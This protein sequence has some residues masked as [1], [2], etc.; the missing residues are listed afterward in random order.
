MNMKQL[1]YFVCIAEAGSL[2]KASEILNIAQPALSQ[3]LQS[4]EQELGVELVT[5]HSRGVMA[6][7]LGLIML[8]HFKTIL[9][10]IDRTHD[11]LRDY[12]LNPS[13]EVTVGI[14]T[15]A[16]RALAAPLVARVNKQFPKINMHVIE[17]MSGSLNES[18]HLGL[19]DLTILYNPRPHL[20]IASTIDYTPVLREDLFFISKN[21]EQVNNKKTI[22]FAMLEGFPLV[23]PCYSNALARLIHDEADKCGTKLNVKFEIDSLSGIIELIDSNFFTIL[24]KIGISKELEQERMVATPITD[25]QVNW[26]VYIAA[27]YTGSR[28]RTIRIVHRT[29]LDLI[30]EM[31]KTGEWQGE[32]L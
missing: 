2:S 19:I 11:L 32:L 10:E 24:P 26:D 30:K 14:P 12:T 3:Q 17:A 7:D 25:P 29:L 13:G 1:R 21:K 16:A 27:A 5:R 4:L 18:L 15:T 23:V 9:L 6:N 22:P 28:S 8:H 20:G 31:V